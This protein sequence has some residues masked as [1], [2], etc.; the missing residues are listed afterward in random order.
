MELTI[1]A[2]VLMAA[3]CLMACWMSRAAVAASERH[4]ERME[5]IANTTLAKAMAVCDCELRRLTIAMDHDIGVA[6]A[7]G[8]PPERTNRVGPRRNL[9]KEPEP[10]IVTRNGPVNHI[11]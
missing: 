7:S 10:D 9:P 2:L 5:K 11:G 8:P 4:S 3:A 1:A 6:G